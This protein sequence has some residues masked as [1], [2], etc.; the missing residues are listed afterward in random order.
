MPKSQGEWVEYQ[1]I[2]DKDVPVSKTGDQ[3]N[4]KSPND[5][6]KYQAKH[7]KNQCGEEPWNKGTKVK[8]KG[9]T[10]YI[11]KNPEQILHGQL[12]R[13]E[14][15]T[16]NGLKMS[17]HQF[18]D[19]PPK[20]YDYYTKE[21][22]P[23]KKGIDD[24]IAKD[25]HEGL[26]LKISG[27]YDPELFDDHN[28]WAVVTKL[29]DIYHYEVRQVEGSNPPELGKTLLIRDTDVK[30]WIGDEK[31]DYV[32]IGEERHKKEVL[33]LIYLAGKR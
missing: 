28:T 25:Y 26:V 18:Y 8:V 9:S 10:V 16:E 21:E 19:L 12:I 6:A 33:P 14:I 22:P 20:Y 5:W 7:L 32:G 15:K 4:L 23:Y 2:L 24:E 3:T 1:T 17:E 13:G 11:F 29:T 30:W 27:D 31:Y